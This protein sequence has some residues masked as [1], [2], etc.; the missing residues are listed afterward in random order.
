MKNLVITIVDFF[1]WIAIIA[2][3][4][5]G[6]SMMAGPMEYFGALFG[7]FIGCTI[8]GGWFVLSSI[9]DNIEAIRKLAESKNSQ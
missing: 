1:A 7:F 3:T 6:F 2:C 5:A 9:H 4:I 8:A